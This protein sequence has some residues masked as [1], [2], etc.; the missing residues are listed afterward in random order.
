MILLE[1]LDHRD[2]L[3]VRGSPAGQERQEYPF[4]PLCR[5][6]LQVHGD[7]LDQVDLHMQISKFKD[8][9]TNYREQYTVFM[10]VFTHYILSRVGISLVSI[11]EQSLVSLLH[12]FVVGNSTD[13]DLVCHN[14]V[15]PK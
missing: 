2:L 5:H 15:K 12:I 6:F 3:S 1:I 4:L 9:A 13:P 7:P 10:Q 8:Q 11:Y 14:A